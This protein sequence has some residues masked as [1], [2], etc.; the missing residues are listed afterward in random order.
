[1]KRCIKIIKR[2][3][4]LK[5]G[6]AGGMILTVQPLGKFFGF[7][8]PLPDLRTQRDDNLSDKSHERLL[9]IIHKYG[10]EFGEIKEGLN[11]CF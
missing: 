2:R 3:T 10:G 6:L 8:V 1:M 9:Q 5:T 11:G 4:F 7:A